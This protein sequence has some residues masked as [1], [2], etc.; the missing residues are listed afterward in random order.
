MTDLNTVVCTVDNTETNI[1]LLLQ[2]GEK[3]AD[4]VRKGNRV[5]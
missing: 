5:Q 1:V 4:K 2:R 3:L